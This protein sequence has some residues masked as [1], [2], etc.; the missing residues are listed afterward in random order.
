MRALTESR[1]RVDCLVD[2]QD[3]AE[4]AKLAVKFGYRMVLQPSNDTL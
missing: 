3:V 1:T 4:I 2:Q